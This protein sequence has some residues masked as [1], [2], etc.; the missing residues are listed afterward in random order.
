[1]VQQRRAR[2]AKPSSSA[3]PAPAFSFSGAHVGTDILASLVVFL[4]ALPLCIGIGVASGVP[5]E[6]GI[7]S[8]IVGGL[9]VGLLP[10]SS[11]QVSGPAAGLATLVMEMVTEH[12]VGMLGP[13]VLAT[14]AIQIALG[15]FGLGRLFQAISLS[16]VQGMLAGIGLP[17]ILGQLYAVADSEQH[18][19]ALKNAAGM[20]ALAS[21]VMANHQTLVAVGLGAFTVVLCFV[22]KKV[23][24][25]LGKVPAAL[26]AVLAGSLIAALPGVHVDRVEVNDL[27]AAVH[28]PGLSDFGSLADLSVIKLAI[29][30]AV[31]ASAESLFSAAAVDRMHDGS[32]TKYNPELVAQGVG[33]SL[34][35]LLGA[36]P[37]TA[38]IARSAA[39][40]QAGGKTKLSRILHGLWLLGFGLMLPDLL[41]FVP[42]SV[43]AGV[44]VHAGWKLFDPGQFAKM[45][46]KDRGEGLVMVV[47]FAAIIFTNLLEGV[48]AGLAIATVMAALRM[49]RLRIDQSEVDGT[50]HLTMSGNATFLLLPKL[51]DTLEALNGK[52]RV[53]IDMIG[54]SHLDLACRAQV[55]EWAEQRRQSGAEHVVLLLPEETHPKTVDEEAED[56]LA[57]QSETAADRLPP[58][59]ENEAAI[60]DYLMRQGYAVHPGP[61]PGYGVPYGH[62]APGMYHPPMPPVPTMQPMPS[63][64]PMPPMPQPYGDPRAYAPVHTHGAQPGHYPGAHPAPQPGS[65]AGAH[66]G[67]HPGT[68]PAPHQGWQ[69]GSHPGTHPAPHQGAQPGYP[70]GADP[71]TLPGAHPG[72]YAGPH[73]SPYPGQDPG[74]GPST[75]G[76]GPVRG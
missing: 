76:G 31:I 8:G 38:V 21:E 48:L 46:R 58:W 45:W 24:G 27:F 54:V 74:Y 44:L 41:A 60:D 51:T 23:P 1:M 12:G 26:V 2:H 65:Y 15:L 66:P 57:E 64:P 17:L 71:R 16:V 40:V 70:P 18:G 62:G 69:P 30:F 7:I 36:L 61:P 14:G 53:H 33:N 55:E 20:P 9:I 22:W 3:L 28:I 29:T 4:V 13:V 56:W 43:L 47:T 6:L 10:G 11:L 63:M 73:P 50:T 39:N 52:L 49:S 5:V 72:S 19:S 68:H 34:C 32:K 37:I 42:I 59:H 25:A 35:G 67:H 75:Y